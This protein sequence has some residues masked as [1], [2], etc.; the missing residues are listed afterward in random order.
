M[1]V[2]GRLPGKVALVTGAARGQGRAHCL[3][4]A[5]EGADIIA[6]DVLE[7]N[8]QVSYGLATKQDMD[9][10]Q[11]LVSETGRRFIGLRADVRSQ[12]DLDAAVAAGTTAMG[13]IDVVCVNAGI[14]G[15]KGP[16]WEL[17]E[18]AFEN[19]LQVNLLGAW[20]TV[21]AA[22]PGMI[23]AKRG[24][25]IVF[26]NSTLGLKGIQGL[27]AYTAS[28][29]GLLG[30]ARC[31]AAELAPHDIRV[32]SVAPTGV[33]TPL[34]WNEATY[35][36]FRPDLENPGLEDAIESFR[37]MHQ[38]PVPWVDPV[39]VA[40]AVVFLASDEARCITG[41]ALPVDAGNLNK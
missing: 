18:Q 36:H 3:R 14:S 37:S 39:D 26:I 41:I 22:A 12:A 20:R 40:N 2:M 38:L 21:K 7:D 10:T 23:E 13:G 33:G 5:Q 25:S 11:R 17:E 8:E 29:H 32:N 1:A 27:S 15:P 6:V 24:G 9:E 16:S 35:R 30:L 31:L 28:K 4:M 34:I 19:I